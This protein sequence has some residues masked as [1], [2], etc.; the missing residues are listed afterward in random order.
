MELDQGKIINC[1]PDR[2]FAQLSKAILATMLC[3][4]KTMLNG[5]NLLVSVS[6]PLRIVGIVSVSYRFKKTW[7]RPF[8]PSS[9]HFQIS[10]E[11]EFCV[12]GPLC[13]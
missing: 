8:L 12:L 6:I 5:L 7:N 10:G 1:V 11:T 13:R 2:T 9:V 3:H 4:N